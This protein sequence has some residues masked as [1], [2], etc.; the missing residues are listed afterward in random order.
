MST[1]VLFLPQGSAPGPATEYSYALTT[2]GHTATRHDSAPA[3]LLPDP[4]RAGEVVAVVPIRALSWQRV[5]LPQGAGAQAPRL[6]AVLEGLLE[7]RLLDDPQQLHF[8]LEPGARPGVPVW[9]A[10]CDR[11]WLRASLQALEAAGRPVQRIVPEFAPGTG[12][13]SP[14]GY[15]VIG[16]P[17]DPFL[18]AAGQ[19]PD[20][21]PAVLPL[22]PAALQLTGAVRPGG[23]DGPGIAGEEQ[24]GA[25]PE[26]LAEPAVTTVTERMLGR[27]AVLHT[28]SQRALAAARGPWDLAQFEFA[29]NRRTRTLRKA[30]S[31][32]GTFARAPQW[33]AA[34]WALGVCVAAQLV[35]LNAWAWQERQALAAKQAGIR[36]AL[37]QTFPQVQVVVDAPVQ[38]EREVARLR[39]QAGSVSP[40][41]LEPLLAAAGGALPAGRLPTAIDYASGELRL[42]GIEL[43]PDEL[44]T[45]NERLAA[46]GYQAAPQDGALLVR[47][48]ARP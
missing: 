28:A 21:V 34:R 46:A 41:D 15:F 13:E 47:Q 20:A 43:Q 2:D 27:P 19:G 16:T 10:V 32:F 29:S 24:N 7:E 45:A 31:V 25:P 38:M 33:R 17:E 6:R 1:L 3:P 23:P 5:T 9:V 14:S 4:G 36:S 44:A 12:D 18:V 40:R 22:S 42:R 37:T 8:A 39:Q 35:G 11:A 30:G 26:V 48:G